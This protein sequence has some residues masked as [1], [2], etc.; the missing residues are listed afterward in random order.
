[1]S[2]HTKNQLGFTL[3]ELLVAI[4]I[5][6]ILSTIGIASFNSAN[7]RN[8]VKNQAKEI[9]SLMRK[10][11]TDAVAAYKP[12]QCIDN[13]A[14]LYGTYINFKR[15]ENFLTYGVSCW[16]DGATDDFSTEEIFQLKEGLLQSS[17]FANLIVFYNFDGSV[18]YY[19]LGL[20]AQ[21]LAMVAP[22]KALIENPSSHAN[23]ANVNNSSNLDYSV[24][25]TDG[26]TFVANANAYGV[27]FNK[28][29]LV[30]DESVQH[31]ISNNSII[32]NSECASSQP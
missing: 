15:D 27:S 3:V 18:I 24:V 29:G 26:P 8:E 5:I 12:Q 28:S 4:V 17:G 2:K 22:T 31:P 20:T 16:G 32:N 1:M 21:E 23:F 19:D 6:V 10:L 25:V 13:G 11:R 7:S 14:T 30:C 9:K